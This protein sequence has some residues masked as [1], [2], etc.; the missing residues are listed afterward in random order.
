LAELLAE[1]AEAL[2]DTTPASLKLAATDLRTALGA[3]AYNA[4]IEDAQSSLPPGE[5]LPR[6]AEADATTLKLLAA[7]GRYMRA[8]ERTKPK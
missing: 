5:K 8:Y 6:H 4:L 1:R 3:T 7:Q 2:K